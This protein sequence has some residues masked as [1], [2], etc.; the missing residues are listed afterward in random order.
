M[1]HDGAE[2]T[3]TLV[4]RNCED[5]LKREFPDIIPPPGFSPER[6]QHLYEKIR[7]FYPEEVYLVCINFLKTLIP[8][9]KNVINNTPQTSF[10]VTNNVCG[11]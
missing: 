6:Q 3:F 7:E 10:F 2:T 5:Q 1:T 9:A 8:I 4:H 11:V